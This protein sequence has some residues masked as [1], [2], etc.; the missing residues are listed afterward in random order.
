MA[1][2]GCFSLSQLVKTVYPFTFSSLVSNL[3]LSDNCTFPITLKSRTS[4]TDVQVGK[5]RQSVHV[6]KSIEQSY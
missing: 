3:D 5:V 6:A 2:N 4:I 1:N